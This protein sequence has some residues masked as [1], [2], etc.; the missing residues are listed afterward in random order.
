MMNR[1]SF[2]TGGLSIFALARMAR[3]LGELAVLSGRSSAWPLPAILGV[4]EVLSLPGLVSGCEVRNLGA[5]ESA[6]CA[7][8][9]RLVCAQYVHPG[10]RAI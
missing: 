5:L 3:A 6:V 4:S 7:R 8:T 1:R 2:L 9:G 10:H